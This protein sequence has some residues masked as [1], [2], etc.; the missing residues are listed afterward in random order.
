MSK[1]ISVKEAC[2]QLG[3]STQRMHYLLKAGRVIG[4]V[5]FASVWMV[6]RKLVIKKSKAGRPPKNPSTA[7]D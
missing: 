4:A 1:Y 2:E 6:P 5:K 7:I 3:F